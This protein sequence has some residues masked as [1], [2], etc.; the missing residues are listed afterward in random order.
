MTHIIWVICDFLTADL[1]RV[2]MI[3][4]P[5]NTDGLIAKLNSNFGYWLSSLI[6]NR[7]WKNDLFCRF[8]WSNAE[9][10][11]QLTIWN[12]IDETA[13]VIFLHLRFYHR[14]KYTF[15]EKKI[16]FVFHWF[17]FVGKYG[18]PTN[19]SWP[20]SWYNPSGRV[21]ASNA[22]WWPSIEAGNKEST[23]TW[24]NWS[25]QFSSQEWKDYICKSKCLIG[26]SKEKF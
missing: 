10:W 9:N 23:K 18:Q 21:K 16:N 20:K 13:K 7:K 14:S 15:L 6:A 4:C 1:D 17:N 24:T 11:A 19:G 26:Y 8:L 12:W 3:F 5:H 22:E 2:L 25:D